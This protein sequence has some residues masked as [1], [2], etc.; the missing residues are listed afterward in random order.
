MLV[1]AEVLLTLV[2]EEQLAELVV[3]ELQ[4]YLVETAHQAFK[5]VR[6]HQI[7]PELQIL[8]VEEEQEL[9]T[10]AKGLVQMV[11]KES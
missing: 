6:E 8:E 7:L 10:L 4:E 9:D 11:V 1:A 5:L 2:L 3:Q